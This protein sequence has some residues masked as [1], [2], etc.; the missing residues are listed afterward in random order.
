M[1]N[2]TTQT[3]D[4]KTETEQLDSLFR[5][6]EKGDIIIHKETGNRAKVLRNEEVLTTNGKEQGLIVIPEKE[7]DDTELALP[8]SNTDQYE[9]KK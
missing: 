5:N 9:V 6:V 8:R 7:E 3:S 4:S 1:K 2:E